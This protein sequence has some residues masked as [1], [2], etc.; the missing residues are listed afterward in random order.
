MN[1]NREMF[2]SLLQ[3]SIVDYK[4]CQRQQKSTKK[5]K[6]N[7][8]LFI[9]KIIGRSKTSVDEVQTATPKRKTRS[10]NATKKSVSTESRN[11]GDSG[12]NSPEVVQ[13]RTSKR[14]KNENHNDL[15][16]SKVSQK[17]KTSIS[18]TKE[19][20]KAVSVFLCYF[21]HHRK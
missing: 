14:S 1:V 7:I 8:I 19:K 20:T 6:F 10:T 13:K 4:Q 12:I 5:Q 15:A 3:T 21:S 11:S 2:I 16:I 9:S 17:S 18:K